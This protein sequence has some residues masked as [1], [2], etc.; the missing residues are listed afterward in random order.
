MPVVAGDAVSLP[1][2]SIERARKCRYNSFIL[3]YFGDLPHL[4]LLNHTLKLFGPA[5]YN[6]VESEIL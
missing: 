2:L 3:W 4:P 6:R 5:K 1:S